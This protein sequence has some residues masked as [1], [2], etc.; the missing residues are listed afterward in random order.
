[1]S[2]QYDNN[3]SGALFKN[4]DKQQD[5]HPDYR[6]NAEIDGKQFWV[7]AWIA[8]AKQSGKKYMRLRFKPKL[9]S[10]RAS[11]PTGGANDPRPSGGS[12]W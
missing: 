9:A 7:D 12:R 3:M 2:G 4:E 8:T 10:D 1:M 5:S 6:G 11:P